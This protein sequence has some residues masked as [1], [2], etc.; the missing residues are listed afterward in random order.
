MP[1]SPHTSHPHRTQL[2]THK[3][4][5]HSSTHLTH[6]HRRQVGPNT[7]GRTHLRRSDNY[8]HFGRGQSSRLDRRSTCQSLA[9]CSCSTGPHRSLPRSWYRL[10]DPGRLGLKPQSKMLRSSTGT[11]CTTR[12][13]ISGLRHQRS[14]HIQF[15]RFD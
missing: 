9:S 3:P 10:R 1:Y 12:R 6:T 7:P 13:Q 4:P 5:I 2:R 14:W 8:H 15:W 11:L